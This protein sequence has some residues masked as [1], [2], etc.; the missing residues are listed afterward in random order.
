MNYGEFY[1]THL[2][3]KAEVTIAALP[4][5]I[6]MASRF[7][8]LQCDSDGVVKRFYEKPDDDDLIQELSVDCA[9]EKCV[10][11]SMGIY[12]FRKDVLNQA[13]KFTGNDFGKNIIPAC[14]ENFKTT[15]YRFEGYWEDIGTIGSFFDSNIA[16]TDEKPAF[17]FFDTINP[18]FTRPRFLPGSRV[19]GAT[20]NNSIINEGC[21]VGRA[22]IN[23][24]ILG[25]R[26]LVQNDVDLNQVYMMGADIYENRSYNNKIPM[27][28]GR[29]SVL[30]RVILD[31]NV[32]IGRNVRLV[33]S[34]GLD[35]SD[36]EIFTIRD[37]IVVIPKNTV[38]PDGTVI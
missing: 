32:R 3:S 12:I 9:E 4:I 14:L 31:K 25:T 16:L 13:L 15:V 6:K 26:S 19:E 27:G 28:I 2:E 22:R 29:G 24:S 23:R 11:G 5:P 17:S 18:I 38:I 37:G 7:G 1:R 33:N 10:L 34:E 30:K 20:V 35:R 8:V 36:G 21:I